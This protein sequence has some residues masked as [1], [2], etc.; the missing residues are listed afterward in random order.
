M[1][2]TKTAM[3]TEIS[4]DGLPTALGSAFT[5]EITLLGQKMDSLF[6]SIEALT[7]MVSNT[8]AEIAS[9]SRV[10]STGERIGTLNGYDTSYSHHHVLDEF[11]DHKDILIDSDG[12]ETYAKNSDRVLSPELQIQRLTAQ[13]TAAYNRI[14]ALE[15][16]L[17]S[18][19]LS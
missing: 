7:R 9:P 18:R 13:L 3:P 8:M 1:E 2:T 12:V 6:Q 15:E 11:L 17:L 16:Q 5:T 14:A 19:R 10:A 4:T